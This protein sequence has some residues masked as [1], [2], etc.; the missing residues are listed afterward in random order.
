MLL[1][2]LFPQKSAYEGLK[3]IFFDFV[4]DKINFYKEGEEIINN[5]DKK[6]SAL[7]DESF[8]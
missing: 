1:Y 2:E 7:F 6:S 5:E 8:F 3:L 4:S